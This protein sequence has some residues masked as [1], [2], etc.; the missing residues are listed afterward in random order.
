MKDYGAVSP[1]FWTGE[2]GR[3]LKSLGIEAQLVALYLMT[4]PHRNALG[5]YYLPEIF[6]SHETALD[7]EGALKGLQRCIEGGFCGY[8]RGTETVWVYEMAH[9][10][11]GISLKESDNKVKWINNKFDSLPNNKF[12]LPFFKKYKNDFHLNNGRNIKGLRRGLKAPSKPDSDSDSDSDFYFAQKITLPKKMF[13]T[14]KMIGYANQKGVHKN[15]EE[16]F[17]HFCQHHRKV[18]SKFNDWHAAWQ[19][20]IRK[21]I[22]FN[23]KD[24]KLIK[25]QTMEELEAQAAS[26]E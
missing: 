6:I 23:G 7:E 9:F 16:I 4:N 17:E 24:P 12:L 3:K 15:L 2:T 11:I 22:E 19:N 21:H 8:E 5:L 1:N 14:E 20:W 25:V 13:L 26:N 18:G 10:Q